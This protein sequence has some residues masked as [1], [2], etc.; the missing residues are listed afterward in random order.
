MKRQFFLT[1]SVLAL[2]CTRS[3]EPTPAGPTELLSTI[4]RFGPCVQAWE[5]AVPPVGRTVVDFYYG[6]DGTG[7]GQAQIAAI[8]RA[9]GVVTYAFHLPLVRAEVNVDI[10]P[11][12]IQA[13][14]GG[15]GPRYAITVPQPAS[16]EVSVIVTLDHPVTDADIAAVGALGGR[17]G[18]RY[19]VINGY[20]LQID[21]A[22]IPRLR[23]LS[24]VTDVEL[25]V[26]DC[27]A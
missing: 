8:E 10:V 22:A 18:F 20:S 19:T 24:G 23:A 6:S 11:G 26:A 3:T 27:L 1:V 14:P 13:S 9:G 2:A 5:P 17:V 4:Y 15:A 25:N 7:A 12:L 16:H 21:D